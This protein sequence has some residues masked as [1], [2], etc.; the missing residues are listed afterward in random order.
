MKSVYAE[1]MIIVLII[2]GF[3]LC[4]LDFLFPHRVTVQEAIQVPYMATEDRQVLLERA[5]DYTIGEYSYSSYNLE[6]GKT[7]EISWQADNYVIVYLM[8]ESQYNTFR[9]IRLA[10]NLKSKGGISGTF[11]HTLPYSGKYYVV[12]YN[13]NWFVTRVRIVYYQSKL[14]WQ[15]TVTKYRIEYVSKQVEDD[16]YLHSGLSVIGV[17]LIILIVQVAVE[18]R[19]KGK[20][21]VLRH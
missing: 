17:A 21:G 9:S 19:K 16:L 20:L 6:S 10:Q 7:I 8:T 3:G 14:L 5:E 13:P 15:E 11:S 1:I 2:V 18:H 4:I 12:I